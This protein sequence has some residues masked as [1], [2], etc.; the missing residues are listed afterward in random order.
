MLPL[1]DSE[2]PSLWHEKIDMKDQ[3]YFPTVLII[4][5]DPA[6]T[7]YWREK[8]HLDTSVGVV[9]A[10]NLSEGRR[11]VEKD[12]VHIDGIVSDLYFEEGTADPANE[13]RDGIDFLAFGTRKRAGV[14]PYVMSYFA[15]QQVWRARE[16]EIHVPIEGWFQKAFYTKD[17]QL[18][19]WQEIERDLIKSRLQ[20]N[21]Q[22]R[23]QALSLGFRSVEDIEKVSKLVQRL[24]LPKRTYLQDLGDRQFFV[25]EPIEVICFQESKHEVRA[26]APRLGLLQ[27]GRGASVEDA[28]IDL[29]QIILRLKA[30]FA[31]EPT[32]NIVG[33]TKL[34]KERL[35]ACIE[36]LP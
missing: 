5:D 13:L 1:R 9:I 34:V 6:C 35:D 29:Q 24:A 12:E 31:E 17:D 33:F 14:R 23:K 32:E 21:E 25:R 2:S 16:K 15:E 10:N 30:V 27:D 8:F 22:V 19:P 28:L 4:D 11:L 26:S 36:K 7:T 18:L 20:S 3:D